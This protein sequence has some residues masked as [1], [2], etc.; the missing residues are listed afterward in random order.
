MGHIGIKGLHSAVDKAALNNCSYPSCKVCAWENI[1]HLPFSQHT[2]NHATHLLQHIHCDICGLLLTCYGNFSYF[3]L[4]IDCF[5]YF[6][7]LF[8]MKSQ[9]EALQLFIE[10][11]VVTENFCGERITI[12]C[13]DNTPKL[14]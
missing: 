1:H 5:S 12:L 6:I 14:V 11:Q 9:N 4:F 10:Y 8:L 13:I 7:S 2:T 3:I